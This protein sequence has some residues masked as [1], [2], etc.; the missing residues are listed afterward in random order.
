[1]SGKDASMD[2]HDKVSQSS[3][4]NHDERLLDSALK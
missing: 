2:E 3:P 4:S 1:V